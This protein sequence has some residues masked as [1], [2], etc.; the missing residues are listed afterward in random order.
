MVYFEPVVEVPEKLVEVPVESAFI[1]LTIVVIKPLH[2]VSQVVNVLVA[3]I[4]G[5]VIDIV[6]GPVPPVVTIEVG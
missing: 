6:Q 3:D 5:M 1:L 2:P 4:V